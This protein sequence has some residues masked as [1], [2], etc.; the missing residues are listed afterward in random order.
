MSSRKTN[1]LRLI[2]E[3]ETASLRRISRSHTEPAARVA[4]AAML[5]AAARGDDY[6]QA[7]LAVGRRSGVAVSHLVAR[8]N[9]EDLAALDPRHGGG[10]RRHYDQQATERI[11][12]EARGCDRRFLGFRLFGSRISSIDSFRGNKSMRPSS[13]RFCAASAPPTP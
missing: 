12:R 13:G 10:Q 8:F 6:Q 11:L 2:T 3:D 1:P 4:R 9:A 7:A 5:L